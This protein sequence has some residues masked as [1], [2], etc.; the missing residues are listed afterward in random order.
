MEVNPRR[1]PYVASE[2]VPA[3]RKPT[4]STP[5]A[6]ATAE[7]KLLYTDGLLRVCIRVY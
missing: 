3:P 6:A 5:A 7:P 4:A 2:C 1:S